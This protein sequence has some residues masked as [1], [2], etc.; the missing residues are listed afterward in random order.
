M[1]YAMITGDMFRFSIIYVIFLFGF[2][3]AFYFS[4]SDFEGDGSLFYKYHSTWMGLFHMTLGEYEVRDIKRRVNYIVQQSHYNTAY[5]VF[6]YENIKKAPYN[7]MG[8]F[9]FIMFQIF[10]PI[11]LLNMLIAMMGNTYATVSEKSE[12]EFLKQVGVFGLSRAQAYN[13]LLLFQSKSCC[14]TDGQN[15]HEHG[16]ERGSRPGQEIFGDLQHEVKRFGERCD[17]HQS[18]GQNKGKSAK[19]SS[20]QLEGILMLFSK[21]TF[22]GMMH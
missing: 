4:Q 18:P 10:I 7:N 14:V 15:H 6:Q 13:F 2:S 8:R 3:Q 9:M 11:L 20:I 19:R 1:I 16:E 12:K 5:F 22:H 21:H 17:G